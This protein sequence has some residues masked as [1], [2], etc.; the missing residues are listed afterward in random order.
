MSGRD[1]LGIFRGSSA[2]QERIKTDKKI[3]DISKKSI[4]ETALVIDFVSNPV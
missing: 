4:F 3:Q 1:Y 2:E